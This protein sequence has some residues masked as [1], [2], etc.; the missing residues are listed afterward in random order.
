[1]YVQDMTDRNI[2]SHTF[3][4][5]RKYKHSWVVSSVVRLRHWQLNVF[6][7]LP[8]NAPDVVIFNENRRK[9]FVIKVS[10]AFDH[11]LEKTF[12][13]YKSTSL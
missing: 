3:S 9:V 2:R 10:C 4:C 6:L 1:M 12:L 8:T 13:T 7:N 11:S 5:V